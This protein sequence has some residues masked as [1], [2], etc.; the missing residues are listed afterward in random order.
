MERNK[1]ENLCLL[2]YIAEFCL[3]ITRRLF[4]QKEDNA[5]NLPVFSYSYNEVLVRVHFI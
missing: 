5:K 3:L 2:A 4:M 1:E